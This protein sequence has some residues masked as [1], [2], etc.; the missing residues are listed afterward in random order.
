MSTIDP[1]GRISVHYAG[2]QSPKA[3]APDARELTPARLPGVVVRGHANS[4]F[5]VEGFQVPPG[6]TFTAFLGENLHKVIGNWPAE[7]QARAVRN[8]LAFVE[9]KKPPIFGVNSGIQE[10]LSSASLLSGSAKEIKIGFDVCRRFDP[11]G[12]PQAMTELGLNMEFSSPGV[13]SEGS[14]DVDMFGIAYM[15]LITYDTKLPTADL[16]AILRF[17][18]K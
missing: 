11:E 6:A 16:L 13:G 5:R 17:Q 4:G 1:K 9:K 12:A 2:A 15:P 10:A 14:I 8:L 18:D 7:E 3:A